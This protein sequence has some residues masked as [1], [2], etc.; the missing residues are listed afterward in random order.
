GQSKYENL[1]PLNRAINEI[2]AGTMDMIKRILNPQLI[3]KEGLVPKEA[4]ERFF[5]NMPGGKLK[6]GPLGDVRND[7]RYME[8]PVMPP[9]VFQ[10]LA[11]YLSPEFDRL[12]GFLDAS[13]LMKKG[14][15]PGG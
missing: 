6:L 14:Q 2:G 7:I 8:P 11:Q 1:V 9:Y 13:S 3:A 15:T 4:W 5:P 12:G 10:F